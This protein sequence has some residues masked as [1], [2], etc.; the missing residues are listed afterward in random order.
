MT[1]PEGEPLHVAVDRRSQSAWILGG[2]SRRRLSSRK[3]T[4]IRVSIH[5]GSVSTAARLTRDP[6]LGVESRR[7]ESE[8]GSCL[9]FF[10]LSF[11]TAV[12]DPRARACVYPSG[13][14][15]PASELRLYC[16]EQ[17]FFTVSFY[18]L[19]EVTISPPT[20]IPYYSR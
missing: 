6:P 8:G 10:F 3:Y 16:I 11:F 2:D 20:I 5:L 13:A 12:V 14:R 7:R 15:F 17:L 1:I 4:E 9:A 18:P 19:F